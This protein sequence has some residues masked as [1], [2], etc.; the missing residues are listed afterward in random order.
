MLSNFT[1][2]SVPTLP[3]LLALIAYIMDSFAPVDTGII[4]VDSIST[5]ID[6]A[7][8]R[9]AD[10]R[11][12][13]K[14]KENGRYLG[15]RRQAVIGELASKLAKLA[16][17]KNIAI[18]VTGHVVTKIKS[19]GSAVLRPAISGQDWD[20]TMATR[21]LLFRDWAPDLDFRVD[22][23][24]SSH[25]SARFAGVLKTGGLSL[26]A[27]SEIGSVVAFTIAEVSTAPGHH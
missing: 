16:A 18:L 21:I 17:V 12:T 10:E 7:Y 4:V 15:N 9:N 24:P 1:H 2:Y 3:H 26:S 25:Q 23:S 11:P 14:R 27:K 20:N 13:S 5:L 19:E 6:V 8:P 22:K